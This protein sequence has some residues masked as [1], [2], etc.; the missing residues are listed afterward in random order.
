MIV[1]FFSIIIIPPSPRLPKRE[2]FCRKKYTQFREKIL[3]RT[4]NE[5]C[6]KMKNPFSQ[7]LPAA[8][9]LLL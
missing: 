6:G 3:A 5:K 2:K 8:A 1:L 9:L 7:N 4:E